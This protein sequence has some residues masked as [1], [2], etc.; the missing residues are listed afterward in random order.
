MAMHMMQYP[1]IGGGAGVEG[2]RHLKQSVERL[3]SK[4]R[5]VLVVMVP[6]ADEAF[7]GNHHEPIGNDEPDRPDKEIDSEVD[8]GQREEDCDGHAVGL[9]LEKFQQPLF[10]IRRGFSLSTYE[11]E[12]VH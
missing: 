7:D 6:R 4:H 3:H 1:R 5:N 10:L 2:E 8:R 11:H 9:V 12:A